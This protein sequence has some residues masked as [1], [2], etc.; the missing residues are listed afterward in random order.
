MEETKTQESETPTDSRTEATGGKTFSQEE[1]NQIISERLAKER[2]KAEIEK[3]EAIAQAKAEAERLAKLSSEE[4]QKELTLKQSEELAKKERQLTLRENE[5]NA[6]AKLEELN[7][8]SKFAEFVIDVDT[9]V[10]DKRIENLKDG[11]NKSISEAV[12][13]QLQGNPPK[14]LNKGNS[15][16][17]PITLAF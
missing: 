9:E 3:R 2:S 17:K 13:R 6:R 15:E 1:L 11:W 7:I 14:D 10:M 8:P 12:A 4:K 5:L 16:K